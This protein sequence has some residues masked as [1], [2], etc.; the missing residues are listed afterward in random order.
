MLASIIITTFKRPVFLERAILSCINQN[1]AE[2]YEII[3]VD[4]NGIGSKS[5]LETQQLVSLFSQVVYY[6]LEKN[7]GACIAR[8]KG[9]EKSKGKF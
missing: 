2:D 5:Q 9:V 1:L 8:N 7:S 3:V 4:D 6:P